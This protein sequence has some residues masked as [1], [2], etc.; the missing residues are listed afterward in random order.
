MDYEAIVTQAPTLLRREQRLS[1]RVL[2]LRLQLDNDTLEALL[3]KTSS[4]Y[5]KNPIGGS[6]SIV[7]VYVLLL[8]Y[9]VSG[10]TTDSVQR[11][12]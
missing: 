12:A 7:I 10:L 2:K 8:N 1:Y 5:T 6:R 3:R 4:I 9:N 11:S